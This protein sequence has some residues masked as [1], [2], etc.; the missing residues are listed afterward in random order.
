MILLDLLSVR[1]SY[2][3]KLEM[4]EIF[5]L[6]K[7]LQEVQLQSTTF[8][9]SERSCVELILKLAETN[10]IQV[11]L[12]FSIFYFASLRICLFTYLFILIY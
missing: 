10:A 9:F 5:E 12:L 2:G 1:Q 3:K 6:Q 4:E 8:R 7:K 11:I